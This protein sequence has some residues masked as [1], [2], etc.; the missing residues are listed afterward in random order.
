M[1]GQVRRA[2]SS[3]FSR[4]LGVVIVNAIT[5]FIGDVVDADL[6]AFWADVGVAA[7]LV[8]FGISMS[9]SRLTWMRIAKLGLAETVLRL[10]LTGHIARR[11]LLNPSAGHGTSQQKNSCNL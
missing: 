11:W 4:L 7:N 3:N 10:E 5:V 9:F 6:S 1:S 8:S 2:G